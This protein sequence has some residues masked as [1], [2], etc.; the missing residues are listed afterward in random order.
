VK[1]LFNSAVVGLASAMPKNIMQHILFLLR[2]NPA[3]TDHWEHHLRPIDYYEPLLDFSTIQPSATRHRRQSPAIDFRLTEQIALVR[4]LGERFR[5]ELLELAKPPEPIGFDFDNDYFAGFDAALY[6]A[7][8]RDQR[9][10]RVLEIGS[11]Y[12]TRTRVS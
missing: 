10:G 9:P 12:S 7:L 2:M 4:R 3:I 6:Y 8:I 11:G 1:K 5:P